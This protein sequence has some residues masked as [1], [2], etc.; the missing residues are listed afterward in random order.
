VVRNITLAF[1]LLFI[2]TAYAAEPV[3]CVD[4]TKAN[5]VIA[6]ASDLVSKINR[7]GNAHKMQIHAHRGSGRMPENSMS[8]FREAIRE[9]ADT[10][11]LDLQIGADPDRTVLVAHDAN[12]KP[13]RCFIPGAPEASAT[14]R[15][16]SLAEVKKFDCGSRPQA[17]ANAVPGEKIPTLKEALE[18]LKQNKNTRFNIE[19]KYEDPKFYPPLEEYVQAVIETVEEAERNGVPREQFFFQSFNHEALA[20]LKSKKPEWEV[21]PLVGGGEE[22][23]ALIQKAPYALGA[24]LVTPHFSALTPQILRKLQ[25]DGVK[26]VT[27]TANTRPE[28]LNLIDMGVDG[29]ITDRVDLFMEIK[30][31]LCGQ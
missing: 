18:L 4:D 27:W 5:R 12:T 1:C 11:E 22:G 3:E 26:V 23:Q 2:S 7:C 20:I 6:L 29:I 31:E 19:I 13:A 8:A 9:G 25:S 24:K 28:M 15:K 21:S 16:L 10:I 17:G 14:L 30:K